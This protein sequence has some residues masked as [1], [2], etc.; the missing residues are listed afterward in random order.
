LLSEDSRSGDS[1]AADVG[2]ADVSKRRGDEEITTP[3]N[4][5]KV[6]AMYQIY[7]LIGL[8]VLTWA[9]AIWASFPEEQD[10]T[11]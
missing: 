3:R 4:E 9:I 7:S 10:D 5:R 1:S 8:M 6:N 11:R 2:A